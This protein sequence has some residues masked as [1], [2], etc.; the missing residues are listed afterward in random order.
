MIIE[1]SV[2]ACMHGNI[3]LLFLVFYVCSVVTLHR[4]QNF[5]VVIVVALSV[6][7]LM[8]AVLITLMFVC[9]PRYFTKLTDF[10]SKSSFF[11]HTTLK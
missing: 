9:L 2:V 6:F 8:L 11:L 1:D 10:V 7:V 5:L 4:I 3:A